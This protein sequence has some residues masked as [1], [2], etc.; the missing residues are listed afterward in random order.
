MCFSNDNTRYPNAN[1]QHYYSLLHTR[2]NN[3]NDDY[4][5]HFETRIRFLQLPSEFNPYPEI[6][7]SYRHNPILLMGINYIKFI[8]TDWYN[9]RTTQRKLRKFAP[10]INSYFQV[11]TQHSLY[12]CLHKHYSFLDFRGSI[13]HPIFDFTPT[14]SFSSST[15]FSLSSIVPLYENLT[16]FHHASSDSSPKLIIPQYQFLLDKLNTLEHQPHFR[17]SLSSIYFSALSQQRNLILVL[18]TH[19]NSYSKDRIFII[20]TDTY[21]LQSILTSHFLPFFDNFM[22]NNHLLTHNPHFF[23]YR[24]TGKSSSSISQLQQLDNYYEL[25]SS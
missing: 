5:I 20:D 13:T 15:L 14:D 11:A 6:E 8:G 19:K 21:R 1:Y 17:Q 23:W 3:K 22:E 7:L 4:T 24:F 18:N 10:Y 9:T 2:K 16:I 25:L 12:K